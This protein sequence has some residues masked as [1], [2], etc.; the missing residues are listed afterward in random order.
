MAHDLCVWCAPTQAMIM[1]GLVLAEP[2]SQEPLATISRNILIFGVFAVA[3]RSGETQLKQME[4]DHAS[5]RKSFEKAVEPR[6][7]NP[8]LVRLKHNANEHV[9]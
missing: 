3:P 2:V 9:V 1:T 8:V 4:S 5:S 6:P 7:T